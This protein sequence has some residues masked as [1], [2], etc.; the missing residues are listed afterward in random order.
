MREWGGRVANKG[1]RII[2]QLQL[3]KNTGQLLGHIQSLQKGRLKP[4]NLRTVCSREGRVK[5][6][7]ALSCLLFLMS[8]GAFHKGPHYSRLCCVT[9]TFWEV[10]WRYVMPSSPQMGGLRWS[11]NLVVGG[12]CSP[13]SKQPGYGGEKTWETN[14]EP[15]KLGHMQSISSVFLGLFSIHSGVLYSGLHFLV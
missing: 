7:L 3:C 11:D 6:L 14:L 10:W 12:P 4:F 13:L 2:E 5:N 8:H 1:W 15:Y 9:Q